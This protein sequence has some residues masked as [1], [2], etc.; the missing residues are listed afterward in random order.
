MKSVLIGAAALAV[1]AAAD[2]ATAQTVGAQSGPAP[3][4]WPTYG[5]D[6]GHNRFSPL[7]QITPDNVANL[8]TAWTYPLGAPTAGA[9]GRF[10]ESQVT[11]LVIDGRMYIT[12]GRRTVAALDPATGREI[13]S[14]PIQGP[15][16]GVEYWPGDA[17]HAPAII[18]PAN[19]GLM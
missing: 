18:F 2:F 9:S 13:W 19:G 3:G 6:K 5:R 15:G 12:T 17:T 11:P 16:R 14:H 4:D 1:L 8:T 7:V 10:A